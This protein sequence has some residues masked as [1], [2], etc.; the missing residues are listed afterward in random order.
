LVLEQG[1]PEGGTLPGDL[2][3]VALR[4]PALALRAAGR[5][6]DCCQRAFQAVD[7]DVELLGT[8][9]VGQRLDL[10]AQCGQR[11]TEAVGQVGYCLPLDCDHLVDAVG[12]AVESC[13]DL[14]DLCRS[15]GRGSRIYVAFGEAFRSTGCFFQGSG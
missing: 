8:L 12:Q 5:A 2:D 6:D 11:S 10:Q 7:L 4:H 13:S 15:C 14:G 1:R 9:A 3:S